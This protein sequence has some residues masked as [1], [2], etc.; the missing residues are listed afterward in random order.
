MLDMKLSIYW[1]ICWS[2]V[3][4]LLLPLLFFYVLFTQSG[5]PQIPVPA[6]IAGW[7]LAAVG[8]SFVPLHWLLSISGDEDG[9]F[10]DRVWSTIKNGS[11]CDRTREALHPNNNWGPSRI[12][13]KT[14]WQI[15]CEEFD[16]Y[17]WLPKCIR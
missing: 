1:R 13:E 9:E 10:L 12:K 16:I 17:Y 6:Q 5:V 11:L 15:Y 14:D 2:L 3:C 7:I 8:A 4:P